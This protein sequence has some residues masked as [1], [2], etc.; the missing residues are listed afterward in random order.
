MLI[1]ITINFMPIRAH[2][3]ASIV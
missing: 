1:D 2:C 3:K